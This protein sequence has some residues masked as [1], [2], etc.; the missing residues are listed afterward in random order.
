MCSLPKAHTTR[1]PNVRKASAQGLQQTL[2]QT[3]TINHEFSKTKYI[4]TS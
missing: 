4:M 3:M 1:L 2:S